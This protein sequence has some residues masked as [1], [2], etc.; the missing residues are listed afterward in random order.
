[1]LL[2]GCLFVD[3]IVILFVLILTTCRLCV[4]VLGEKDDD[5]NIN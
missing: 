4:C 2:I 3:V 5:Y 1:V